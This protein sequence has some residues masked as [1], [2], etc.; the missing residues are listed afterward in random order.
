MK[1]AKKIGI[2]I[3]L[4]GLLFAQTFAAIDLAIQSLQMNNGVTTIPQ[5][6]APILDMVIQNIGSDPADNGTNPIGPGFI[7]CTANGNQVFNSQ[8]LTTFVV[9]ANTF[10]SINNIF[11]SNTLTQ[12]VGTKTVTCTINAN[13]FFTDAN[14]ANNSTDVTFTV[15]VLE[16]GRFDSVLDRSIEPLQGNIDAAQLERWPR[17]IVNFIISNTLDLVVPILIIVA[18]LTAMLGFYKMFFSDSDD[19]IKKWTNYILRGIVGI[20]VMMSANYITT[21]LL[22]SVLQGGDIDAFSGV[23]AIQVVYDQIVFPMLKMLIYVILGVLFL[24]LVVRVTKFILTPSEEIRKQ[25]MTIIVWSVVAM[26]II[27][28]STEI[29]EFVYGKKDEILNQNAQNLGDIGTGLLT[30]NIPIIYQIINWVLGLTAF[31]IVAIIIFQSYKLLVNPD[32]E[33]NLA[34]IKKS[35]LYA[36]LGILIIGSW[37]VITNFLIIN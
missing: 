30:N 31:A 8:S 18:V 23:N 28:W 9:G 4:F 6:S 15:V 36:V 1:I 5:G 3:T 32:S 27:L 16:A 33:D 19:E 25:S 37:Y 13:T 17:G 7:T 29:V 12:T 24:L 20:V 2:I 35:I 21:V 11:L 22:N 34:S 14:S 10:Q 26:F